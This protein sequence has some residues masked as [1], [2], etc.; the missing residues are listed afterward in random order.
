MV[1]PSLDTEQVFDL[2]RVIAHFGSRET[3]CSRIEFPHLDPLAEELASEPF[4]ITR[5]FSQD[6][7]SVSAAAGFSKEPFVSTSTKK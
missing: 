2:L 3:F 6:H 4:N 1:L 5:G 7:T